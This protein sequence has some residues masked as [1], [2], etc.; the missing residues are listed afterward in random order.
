MAGGFDR[1]EI[2]QSRKFMYSVSQGD[3]VQV[4]KLCQY[5]IP[6]LVNRLSKFKVFYKLKSL[7]FNSYLSAQRI[8]N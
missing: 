4:E 3:E 7:I 8:Q 1:L 5:G 2:L 6:D